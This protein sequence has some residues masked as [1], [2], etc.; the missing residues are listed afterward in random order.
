MLR[1]PA[2][3]KMKSLGSPANLVQRDLSLRPGTN[4]L[5]AQ[6]ACA[7]WCLPGQ[8]K[9]VP[10]EYPSGRRVNTLVAYEPL[11][12]EPW[13]GSR[14]LE[15]MLTSDDVLAYLQSLPAAVVP[16]VM[17]L[18]NA[19]IHT[20]EQVEAERKASSRKGIYYLYFLPRYSP[21]LNEIEA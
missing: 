15:G 7:S 5:F 2:A 18:Y 10:Y 20:S 3:A 14:A 6:A 21:N 12:A 1:W 8:R 4:R 11:A 9:H 16:R 13:L 19:G 17:V